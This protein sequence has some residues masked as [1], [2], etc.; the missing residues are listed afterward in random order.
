MRM[1]YFNK[2]KTIIVEVIAEL[3]AIVGSLL[4]S[5]SEKE[6]PVLYGL[7]PGLLEDSTQVDSCDN[8]EN[9]DE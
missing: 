2:L 8:T 4:M 1:G 9:N 6:M 5:S 3:V 7:V